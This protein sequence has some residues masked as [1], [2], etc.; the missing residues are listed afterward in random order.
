[1]S[2]KNSYDT[3]GNR[4]RD[5]PVCSVVTTWRW[6][7]HWPKHVVDMYVPRPSN[8]VVLWLQMEYII[9]LYDKGTQWGCH[10]L[11]HCQNLDI[12]SVFS[13]EICLSQTDTQT[14]FVTQI[15][16]NYLDIFQILCRNIALTCSNNFTSTVVF[17]QQH[18]N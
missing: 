2:L 16:F 14:L 18:S 17:N 10:T 4:T 6:P 3:F 13:D 15:V 11:K 8:T 9:W 12:L 5:L 1:M 7:I